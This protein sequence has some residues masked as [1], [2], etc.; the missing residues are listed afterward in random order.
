MSPKK[1]A[2]NKPS[3]IEA[4]RRGQII[5]CAIETIADLGLA[6]A[7]L[8]KI[9][10]RANVS[11]GV[12]LY[13]FA[14]KDELQQ[15]V[16]RHTTSLVSAFIS[17]RIQRGT[18]TTNLLSYVNALIDCY[19]TF[20]NEILT[21]VNIDR[22]RTTARGALYIDREAAEALREGLRQVL[23]SGQ[24]TGE[25]Q[26]FDVSTMESAIQ[27]ILAAIPEQMPVDPDFDIE[28]YRKELL[29]MLRRGVLKD[30]SASEHA[31]D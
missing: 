27:S 13:Y 5:D 9:A 18:P 16:L 12:I 3:F 20:R 28:L 11:T 31:V 21:L 4:A 22:A 29:E 24:K 30:A 15:E 8:A 23:S 2:A 19:A 14:N 17:E 6:Q 25:F 1:T 26:L 7:S 10:K